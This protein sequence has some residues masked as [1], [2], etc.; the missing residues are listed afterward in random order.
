MLLLF[1]GSI[2]LG[3]RMTWLCSSRL[4]FR[5]N[6]NNPGEPDQSKQSRIPIRSDANRVDRRTRMGPGK[7]VNE[8]LGAPTASRRMCLL[9]S[10]DDL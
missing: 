9:G 7:L 2:Q 4:P 1:P 5:K 8:V 10:A 6:Q 3:Y